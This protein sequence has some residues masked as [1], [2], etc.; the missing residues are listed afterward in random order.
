VDA[1]D[2][3]LLFVF[4]FFTRALASTKLDAND[5]SL[6]S[7]LK[8]DAIDTSS[9]STLCGRCCSCTFICFLFFY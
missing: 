1:V 2:L 5:I 8:V 9:T 7:T 3:V 4:N 6:A